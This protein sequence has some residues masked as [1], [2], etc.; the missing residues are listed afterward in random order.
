[1]S[2]QFKQ[3][4]LR[5]FIRALERNIEPLAMLITIAAI[6]GLYQILKLLF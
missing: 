5:I 6:V 2:T 3:A 4:V 1:M